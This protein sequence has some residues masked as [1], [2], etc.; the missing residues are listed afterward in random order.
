[1][2]CK[3][4]CALPL[5]SHSPL[6]CG[7]SHKLYSVCL[8]CSLCCCFFHCLVLFAV[9]LRCVDGLSC[10]VIGLSNWSALTCWVFFLLLFET[11]LSFLFVLV[12]SAFLIVSLDLCC[13]TC[14]LKAVFLSV[15]ISLCAV[16][17]LLIVA[18]LVVSMSIWLV[19]VV[20]CCVIDASLAYTHTGPENFP[21][22]EARAALQ[23]HLGRLFWTSFS[24]L[25]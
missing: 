10:F 1:M 3:T 20:F 15:Q 19:V 4:V 24:L 14:Y 21:I 8:H 13:V 22:Q 7:V 6:W 17:P 25:L 2:Y 16:G 11:S 23:L 12:L 5:L 18:A 9:C